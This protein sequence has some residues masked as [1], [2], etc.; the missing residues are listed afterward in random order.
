FALGQDQQSFRTVIIV[1]AQRG[2]RRRRQ[3]REGPRPHAHDNVL[4]AHNHTDHEA[5]AEMHVATI[6]SV[7]ARRLAV[8]AFYLR[9]RR[10]RHVVLH[11]IFS[12]PFA[13]TLRIGAPARATA[14]LFLALSTVG[15][16]NGWSRLLPR[17]PFFLAL[18][19]C[20]TPIAISSD[21]PL[22][23]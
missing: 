1:E 16:L 12:G 19:I 17:W 23:K 5:I 21:A 2:S 18:D 10:R 20:C 14:L 7:G 4:G 22:N 6:V 11:I 8:D 9:L 15:L 3:R 13:D